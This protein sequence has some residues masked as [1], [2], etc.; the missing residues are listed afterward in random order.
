MFNYT[1]LKMISKTI[2]QQSVQI[3]QYTNSNKRNKEGL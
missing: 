3:R 2:Q 1:I